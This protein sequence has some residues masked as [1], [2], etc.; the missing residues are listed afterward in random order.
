M[1]YSSLHF[2]YLYDLSKLK[3]GT[4]NHDK[5]IGFITP[6]LGLSTYFVI[7]LGF[8]RDEVISNYIGFFFSMTCISTR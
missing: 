3:I 8:T 7:L 6:F 4:V 5:I 1:W 2:F